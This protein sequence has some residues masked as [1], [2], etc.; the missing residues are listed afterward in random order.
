ME[1]KFLS[2]THKKFQLNLFP[3][4]KIHFFAAKVKMLHEDLIF[5]KLTII[6]KCFIGF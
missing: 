2:N 4:P 6:S 5:K 3:M 1:H